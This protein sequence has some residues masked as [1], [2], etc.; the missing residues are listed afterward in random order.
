VSF[1]IEGDVAATST[2]EPG[3]I[4]LLASGLGMLFFVVRRRRRT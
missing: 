4:S 1:T 2:A 3:T